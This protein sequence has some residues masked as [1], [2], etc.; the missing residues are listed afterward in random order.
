VKI[1]LGF[2]FLESPELVSKKGLFAPPPNNCRDKNKKP[3]GQDNM[4]TV[5]RQRLVNA[6]A[7]LGLPIPTLARR[8]VSNPAIEGHPV[9][10]LA[11]VVADEERDHGGSRPIGSCS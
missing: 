7:T 5:I 8:V 2:Y 11:R 1:S 6:S 10:D 3:F 9:G 4:K